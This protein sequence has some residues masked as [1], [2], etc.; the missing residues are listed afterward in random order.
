MTFINLMQSWFSTTQNIR[1]SVYSLFSNSLERDFQLQLE[2]EFDCSP[3]VATPISPGQ[4]LSY[5]TNEI[6]AWDRQ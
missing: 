5:G 1:I 2:L 6:A 4:L 3:A